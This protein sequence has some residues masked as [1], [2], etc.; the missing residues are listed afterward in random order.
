MKKELSRVSWFDQNLPNV[1][2]EKQKESFRQSAV[3]LYLLT[4]IG[5]DYNFFFKKSQDEIVIHPVQ[6][7]E[8]ENR[9][10]SPVL[11][12]HKYK[13][14]FFLFKICNSFFLI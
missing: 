11:A 4:K 14:F 2:F 7:L 5:E 1:S 13:R 9:W 3:G 6:Y 12:S 10:I 8:A